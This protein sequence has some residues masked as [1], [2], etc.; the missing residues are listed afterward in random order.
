[1]RLTARSPAPLEKFCDG[2][3]AIVKT[4]LET[5]WSHGLHP[6]LHIALTFPVND[7]PYGKS[8]TREGAAI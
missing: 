5:S 4:P 3:T 8:V 6:L 2:H 1:M 7:S